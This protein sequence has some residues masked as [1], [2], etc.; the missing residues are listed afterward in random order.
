MEEM[1]EESKILLHKDWQWK[2]I[3]VDEKRALFATILSEKI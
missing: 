1:P 2:N 3:F